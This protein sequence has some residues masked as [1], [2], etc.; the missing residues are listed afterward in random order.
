MNVSSIPNVANVCCV[1]RQQ[2]DSMQML[3]LMKMYFVA[4]PSVEVP[5]MSP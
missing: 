5:A 3:Q 2:L 4:P 1:R